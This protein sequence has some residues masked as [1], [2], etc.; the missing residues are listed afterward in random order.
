MLNMNDPDFK[1][2]LKYKKKYN[3]L[4]LQIELAGGDPGLLASISGAIKSTGSAA[5]S[6]A[7]T[8]AS[9]TGKA[10]AATGK[11]ASAAAEAAAK[12]SGKAAVHVSAASKKAAEAAA[13]ATFAAIDKATTSMN[14]TATSAYIT[15]QF[16]AARLE[17]VKNPSAEN[18]LKVSELKMVCEIAAVKAG[19]KK[20]DKNGNDGN[21]DML[22]EAPVIIDDDAK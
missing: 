3:D 14:D 4:K 19:Y 13:A 22:P 8:V 7:T 9:A 21:C 15:S 12:A 5:L 16:D 20:K 2:Y 6:A 10:A 1:K 18:W 17:Y 11:A